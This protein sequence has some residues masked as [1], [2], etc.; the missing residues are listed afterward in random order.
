MSDE[1][2]DASVGDVEYAL[3]IVGDT[4]PSV[5]ESKSKESFLL[6]LRE[7]REEM[8]LAGVPGRGN[9]G[10]AISTLAALGVILGGSGVLTF[11]C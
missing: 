8:V 5:P 2:K 11:R 6:T 1:C 7:D 9:G 3:S 10:G 4:L